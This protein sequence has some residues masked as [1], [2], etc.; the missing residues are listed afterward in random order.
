M[1]LIPTT[2]WHKYPKLAW[3]FSHLVWQGFKQDGCRETAAALTYTT[4]F[5][6]VPV[7][8]VTFTILHALPEMHGKGQAI[9]DWLFSFVMP[10]ADVQVQQYLQ[11]FAQQAAHLTGVGILFLVVTSV[12]ML[13]TIEGTMNQ[14]WKVK[15]PRK[16][17]TSLLM[18]W[19]VLTLGPLCLGVGLVASSYVASM[20]LFRD[21]MHYF[22]I[23]HLVLVLVPVLFTS[24]LLTLL[25][26]VV[27]NC[28]V[29]IKKGIAGGIVAAV[30]F[31][32]A[33]AAFVQFIKFSPSYK[34]V[35]GAFAAVPL[36][37]L[38]IFISWVI[39]LWGAEFVR[40]LVVFRE[41][42]RRVPHLQALLRLLEALWLRQRSGHLLKPSEI[43]NVLIV[44]GVE[45]WDEFRNLLLELDLMRRTE[46]SSYVLT[47]DLSQLTLFDLMQQLPWSFATQLHVGTQI[48]RGWE[49]TLMARCEQAKEG[50]SEALRV[51]LSELFQQDDVPVVKDALTEPC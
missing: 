28:H 19:A 45:R 17:L 6:I 35:Y 11:G 30:L 9:Q 26:I 36:F 25:Y 15:V 34:L 23:T 1:A 47:R 46:E 13:R 12:L 14:V 5:A 43:R 33:K 2:A 37:L 16:G 38:W 24:F 3:D 49:N 4:L 10:S 18:Y 40:A 51:P 8:T 31:E 50:L 22:G 48:Q 41:T 32:L 44:A 21:T 42:R 27:P 39:V 20:A 29:P 7:M